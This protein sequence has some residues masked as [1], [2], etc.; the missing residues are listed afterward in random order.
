M[1]TFLKNRQTKFLKNSQQKFWYGLN[2][3]AVHKFA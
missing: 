3:K 1:I 2:E